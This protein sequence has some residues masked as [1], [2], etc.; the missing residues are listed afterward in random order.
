MNLPFRF[1]VRVCV[2]CL[3]FM[4]IGLNNGN[5][6]NVKLCHGSQNAV[7]VNIKPDVESNG[8]SSCNI[9]EIEDFACAK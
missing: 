8:Y 1:N 2:W 9:F 6:R 3:V 7:R 5:K 4:C